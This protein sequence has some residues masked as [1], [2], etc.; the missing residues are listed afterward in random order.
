MISIHGYVAAKP[1]LGAAD[2]GGQIVYVLEL[3]KKLAALGYQVDIWTRLFASQP[4]RHL[5]VVTL[6]NNLRGV[7]ALREVEDQLRSRGENQW[8]TAADLMRTDIPV[9]TPET[10]LREA[11]QHFGR[12]GGERLP[13]VNSMQERLL[14][15][16][17]S[18]TDLLLTLA[19]GLQG[20]APLK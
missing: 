7:I 6:E 9:V 19:H 11:L 2:T 4:Y 1:P 13:V 5:M 14:K 17:V 12:Y 20:G 10:E 3:S 8:V 18:K 15:G 16:S